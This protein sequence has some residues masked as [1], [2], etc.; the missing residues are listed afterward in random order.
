MRWLALIALWAVS[1]AVGLHLAQQDALV[2]R[3]FLMI[4]G[5]LA[6]AVGVGALFVRLG[7]KKQTPPG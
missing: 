4:A 1:G 7:R 6:L 5:W 2:T 3:D